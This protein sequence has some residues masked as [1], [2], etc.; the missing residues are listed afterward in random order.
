[1]IDFNDP[2]SA[3]FRAAPG[4]DYDDVQLNPESAHA[5]GMALNLA[6]QRVLAGQVAK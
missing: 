2:E 4:N 3:V 5:I 1:M 6:F